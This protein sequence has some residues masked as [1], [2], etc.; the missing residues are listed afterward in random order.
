[1]GSKS[2]R[3]G[4]SWVL[5]LTLFVQAFAT[6]LTA[7]PQSANAEGRTVTLVGSLQN[8]L[9]AE[10]EWDPADTKTVMAQQPDGKYKL[11]GTLPAGSYEYKIA[12]NGSWDENYGVDGVKGGD[13]YKMTLDKETNVT[14]IYDDTTHKVTIPVALPESDLPRIVGDIQPD[15]NAGGEWSPSESTAILKD[16]DGDNIYTYSAK[17]P[18][19]KHEFKIVL[20]NSWDKPAYPQDNFKLAVLKDASITFFY[21]HD[22]KAVY[23]DYDPGVPDGSVQSD[24]LYHDTWNNA[25]RTPFGAVKTGDK[26]K[27]RLQAKKGDLTAAKAYV[28]NYN[29]GSTNVINMEYAGWLELDGKEVEL[30]EAVVTPKEKGVY[31]Y[32][33]IARDGESQKEYGEDTKEGGTGAAA[34][35][36]AGLFQ[37]TVFDPAYKTPDWMKESVVY[38]IFPDRFNNGNKKNDT[39]KTTA[40]GTEPIEHQQWN[41]LPDNPRQAENPDYKGDSIW[42]NDFFGGDIAGIKQKLDYIQSLGV[43]TLYLNPVAH[44][45]SNHKYDATDFKAIDPMFGTPEEFKAFTKELKKRKMH[46]ILDGVFNHVGDDSIYFDRYSKY[47]TVGAYEYWSAVYDLV[48]KGTSE[49]AAKKQ[50][51]AK[52]TAEGQTFSPYG[53]HNWFNIDNEK[54]NGVYKYQ[55]WWGFDSLPEIESIPGKAVDYN[56]E[57]NNEKFADYIMYDDDSVAKSWLDRGA[58]GWRLDVANEVD[59]EFWRE[60]RDE[61]KT[62]SDTDPLILGEIW[63]DASKYFLGDQYDSVMNYRFRGALIDYLKNG[64]AEGAESQLNAVF[65]DYPQEAFYALMNLMGSHDTPRAAFVLGNGTDTYERAELDKKY[66]H[67]LGLKRLKLA[68]VL[69]M[70]YA[71]APTV[72]YGDE[73][74]VTGSKDPDDRRTYP[75]GTEDKT[76][77]KHYQAVGKVRSDYHELFSYGKLHNLYAKGDVMAYGRTDKKDAAIVITNRGNEA[78]TVELNVADLLV[79]GLQLKDQLDKAYKAQVKNGKL[80]ITVPGMTGRML[81]IEKGENNKRP[82]SVKQVYAFENSHKALL[83]WKGSAKS[84]A[85]YQ[86]TV[87][88]AFYKKIGETKRNTFTVTGLDNGRKYYFAVAAIDKNG[89][90]SVKKETPKAVIPHVELK[91]GNYSIENVTKLANGTLDLSQSQTVTADIFIKGETES[92]EAEGLLGKLQVK[93]PGKTVWTDVKA[94][95]TAQNG[96][97]NV[98]SASFL[99]VDTGSYEYRY[100][101][102]TNLG[103]TWVTSASQTVNFVKGDDNTPPAA[104]IALKQPSQESG[105]VNLSWTVDGANDPYM[106]AI[107]RDGVII[108][109]LLDLSK[110]TYKD[111]NVANGTAYNYEIHLYDKAGNVVKSNAV[112][113][114]PD[115]V[116]VKVTFKVNAPSYTEQGASISI[117]G[118]GNGWNTGA[119]TMTRGGAVTNDYEYTIEAQEGE[120]L[121]YKYVKNASWDQE[122]LADH[123]PGNPNDDDIS[124]YGYGAPGTDMSVVVTNQGGNEMVIQDKILR[125]ID[126]PVVI[127]SH[128]DGQDVAGDTITLKGNAI[129]QG[130]LTING[131]SV[132][133]NDDMTFSHTVKLAAGENKLQIH[134]EPTEANKSGIFKND[135]GAIAKNTKDIVFTVNSK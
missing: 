1:M 87:S 68:A 123:T 8:E 22:T 73:A 55:A 113:V 50:V 102:S 95:Y 27:L 11:S 97:S 29:S 72:Y 4:M 114:T 21:N 30:W 125:W 43:N 78:K 51:E 66:D 134:I 82:D 5:L 74:G 77:I 121:T 49:E 128:A 86:T 81:T 56:S 24:K 98:Y 52:L 90:E 61:L 15:L 16:E 129:K 28:R 25:Y 46:L 18:K 6:S 23:T 14:F 115:L 35:S 109:R 13:N 60:F 36:N 37:M 26:V 54:V 64:N 100:A 80:S 47:K 135:G 2:F 106:A 79:N 62:G 75:W 111:L 108:D 41:N 107:V 34:D 133:V 119:W 92:D 131:E 83:A 38:Q 118:S 33:F 7:A 3:S 112:N 130:V 126:Q 122:G 67:E 70:G 40:R 32:K 12:I 120:V 88:G 89:N 31:G 63:D 10:K 105:Q 93:E 71:G 127:T 19:G 116:M 76:L 65:E 85:V 103:R 84:Y 94:A 101:F 91:K 59:T 48:N 132:T 53:F 42:S 58:S 110:T 124:Y 45:A 20:G 117:P 44:A 9:G 39:A 69:Q 104:G 99:P 17:V 96:T 57:L